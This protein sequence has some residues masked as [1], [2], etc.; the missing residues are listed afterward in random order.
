[1]QEGEKLCE[2]AQDGKLIFSEEA[3]ENNKND[4]NVTGL[5][6]VMS[7]YALPS[8]AHGPILS[9]CQTGLPEEDACR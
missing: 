2:Y 5:K 6:H 8:L 7:P 4:T 1:M 3:E 9:L